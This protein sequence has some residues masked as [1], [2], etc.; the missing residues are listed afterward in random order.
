M[1]A[2]M[3]WEYKTFCEDECAAGQGAERRRIYAL[4]NVV[5][6]LSVTAIPQ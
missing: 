4:L 6:G 2:I 5:L 1:F 3:S